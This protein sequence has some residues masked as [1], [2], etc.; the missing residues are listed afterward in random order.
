[1]LRVR[2]LPKWRLILALLAV[3]G[4]AQAVAL[5]QAA[6]LH[7]R[8]IAMFGSSVA[9]GRGD[10]FARDGYTGLLRAM[11]ASRGWEV[12]NQ[13]RGGDSTKTLPPR[14]APEG[15]PDPKIRYLTTVNPSY[16]LIGLSFGNEGL[17]EAKTKAEKDAVYEG[18]LTGIKAVVDRAR[19]SNIVPVVMLCYTRG[20]Y[21]AEDY[22]YVRRANLVQSTWDV[23]TV[24]VLGAIDDGAGHWAL[25][26][27]DKHPQA[28]GHREMFYAFVPTLFEALEKGKAAPTRAASARGFARIAGAGS[29]SRPACFARTSSQWAGMMTKKTFATMIVPSIA[30]SWSQTARS[31]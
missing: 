1:M 13:S 19:Q 26:W 28:S 6:R 18:Y 20:V 12:L 17:Y 22:E 27:D 14:F 2:S 15:T 4:L 11:M 10:E 21:T 30:P 16:V 5:G 8:R 23:P 25:G 31:K 7:P 3:A 24:N 29:G 9:N